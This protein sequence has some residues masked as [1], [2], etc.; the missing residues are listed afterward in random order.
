MFAA[1]RKG[2]TLAKFE[3]QHRHDTAGV[4]KRGPYNT[5]EHTMFAAERK[6]ITLANHSTSPPLSKTKTQ[7]E[8]TTKRNKKV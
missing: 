1:E 4:T 6:G 2:K 3:Q 7:Q 8:P 5:H